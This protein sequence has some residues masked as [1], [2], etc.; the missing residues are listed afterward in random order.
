MIPTITLCQAAFGLAGLSLG[1]QL[2]SAI[3]R[4]RSGQDSTSEPAP[5]V[6]TAVPDPTEEERPS[7]K[8]SRAQLLEIARSLGVRNARWRNAARKTDLLAAIRAHNQQR[9]AA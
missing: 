7:L 8:L 2:V 9:R 1:M 4:S 5:V 3:G 6:L